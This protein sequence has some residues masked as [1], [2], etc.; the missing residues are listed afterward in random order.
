[1]GP[2]IAS[3]GTS[4]YICQAILGALYHQW[5]TGEGQRVAVSELGTL[6]HQRAVQWTSLVD[7]DEWNGYLFGYIKPPDHPY[8]TKDQPVMPSP[9]SNAEDLP[10]FMRELGMDEYVDDPRFQHPPVYL[11]GWGTNG[12]IDTG[13][14]PVIVKPIWEQAFSRF[15]AEELGEIFRKYGGDAVLC[16]DYQ[17][18]VDHPQI[19]AIEI[20][21]ELDDPALGRVRFQRV[22]WGLDGVPEPEPNPF[23]EVDTATGV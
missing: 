5:R 18:L 14:T 22:P 9:I 15:T 21:R 1:M 2:D 12:G 16:N 20:F 13:D 11:L 7:P 23:C 6:L 17:Q 19:Q 10:A 8:L 3:T 4:L